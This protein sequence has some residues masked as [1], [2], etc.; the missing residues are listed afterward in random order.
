MTTDPKDERSE[1]THNPDNLTP[2][3]VGTQDGW[4]LLDRDELEPVDIEPPFPGLRDLEIWIVIRWAP[5]NSGNTHSRS[6]RTKLTREELRKARGLAPVTAIDGPQR[7]GLRATIDQLR[8]EIER[9]TRER[10]ELA[11]WK[12][13]AMEVESRWDSQAVAREIALRPGQDIRP[14]ILPGILALRAE[15]SAAREEARAEIA[16][17][18]GMWSAT[19]NERDNRIA[20]VCTLQT[21]L[22]AANAAREKSE[23][24]L[25]LVEEALPTEL[26][27]SEESLGSMVASVV[28][29][30]DSLKA[31]LE[32]ERAEVERLAECVMEGNRNIRQAD[33][34]EA[35][36]R[37]Q[38]ASLKSE[39][40]AARESTG[41]AVAAE[42][43]RM[44]QEMTVR[45]PEYLKIVTVGGVNREVEDL[46]RKLAE[47]EVKLTAVN[48]FAN[49]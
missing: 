10:D 40:C 18:N 49:Y 26:E 31:A 29:G 38:L 33:E 47:A 21:L 19:I 32:K 5:Y 34:T 17:I 35:E 48:D 39:L 9:L 37:R 23:Q 16:R 36:M 22:S 30:R 42:T 13:S 14:A 46:R 2:E 20:E 3:Q 43:A 45:F 1:T 44:Q 27:G 15:L 24:Q 12:A 7:F 28:Y 25:L 11:G 41:I 6:Y 8:A 4:R